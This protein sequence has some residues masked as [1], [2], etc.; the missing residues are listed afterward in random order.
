MIHDKMT[1]EES[2]RG[3]GDDADDTGKTGIE[4]EYFVDAGA[5]YTHGFKDGYFR[6]VLH[7]DEGKGR[8]HSYGG[9][10]GYTEYDCHDHDFYDP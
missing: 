4:D 9:D 2:E 10:D 5:F 8:D 6:A 1:G 7:D 3:A